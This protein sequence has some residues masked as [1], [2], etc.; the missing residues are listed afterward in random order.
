MAKIVARVW[1]ESGFLTQN[2][3]VLLLNIYEKCQKPLG[4]PARQDIEC[5]RFHQQ[6][7]TCGFLLLE[8]FSVLGFAV[9]SSFGYDVDKMICQHERYSLS[10]NTKLDLEVT[11]KMAEVYVEEL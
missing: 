10:T 1:G 8:F 7:K 5:L 6:R 9:C 4:M 2:G 3:A 11:K